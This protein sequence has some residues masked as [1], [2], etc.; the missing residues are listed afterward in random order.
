[1]ATSSAAADDQV[2][3]EARCGRTVPPWR[4][5]GATGGRRCGEVE[6]PTVVPPRRRSP[7]NCCEPPTA[8][9]P[10]GASRPTPTRRRGRRRAPRRVHSAPPRAP[11]CVPAAA[12][13]A[14]LDAQRPRRPVPARRGAAPA[15]VGHGRGRRRRR[16]RCREHHCHRGAA[17]GWD[18]GRRFPLRPR[19]RPSPPPMPCH[20]DGRWL[21]QR[22][23]PVKAPQAAAAVAAAVA[24]VASAEAAAAALAG[25]APP[26]RWPAPASAAAVDGCRGGGGRGSDDVRCGCGGGGGGDC[27]SLSQSC[28]VS[29]SAQLQP[30]P[31]HMEHG[32]TFAAGH[33]HSRFRPATGAARGGHH[34]RTLPPPRH[35][36]ICLSVRP[37]GAQLQAVE[38]W[39]T[40]VVGVSAGTCGLGIRGSPA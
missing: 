18:A 10:P 11:P 25:D 6:T 39:T 17:G 15:P 30:R 36:G 9:A 24:V 28:M 8:T 14:A 12:L 32:R 37:A 22:W 16:R 21:P 2:A 27:G 13:G 29:C 40:P 5:R 35:C 31:K 20:H 38:W 33:S 26:R 34:L 23:L 19:S 7:A 1:M 4:W 3:A